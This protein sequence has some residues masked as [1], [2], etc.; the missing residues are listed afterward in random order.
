MQSTSGVAGRTS[1]DQ[2]TP[3]PFPSARTMAVRCRP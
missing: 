3:G 1:S 2:K